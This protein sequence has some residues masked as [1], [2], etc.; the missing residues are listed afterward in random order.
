MHSCKTCIFV[1]PT[2][3]PAVPD[4]FSI[5]PPAVGGSVFRAVV[6]GYRRIGIIDGYF[7]NV[8][9]VWHKEILFA[10][11]EGVE[12][13][14]AASTGALR[15]AE[16]APFGM[17]G[18]GLI[19]RL[20]RSSVLTDDDEVC[21][22]HLSARYNYAALTHAMITVRIILRRLRRRGL[23]SLGEERIVCQNV[24]A[25]H[26]SKR[27]DAAIRNAARAIGR[28]PERLLHEFTNQY[29]DVKALDASCLIRYL[30][31]NTVVMDHSR[32]WSFPETLSWR[33][34][35]VRELSDV[36]PLGVDGATL[37]E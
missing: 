23:L 28:D 12:V 13:C 18:F 4:C 24:K 5:L 8:P 21:V 22:T 20:Y 34:Q 2:R 10:L 7:G 29:V 35:F 31:A 15:A 1:G 30:A 26:F 37:F 27:N 9:A 17:R 36:P 11:S 16:L 33:D 25:M 3:I 19:Y 32:D 14:G 6:G